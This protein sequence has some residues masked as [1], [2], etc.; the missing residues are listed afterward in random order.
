MKININN[1]KK[2]PILSSECPGWC[3]YA[4]KSIGGVIIDHMSEV[5][6]S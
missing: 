4:E 3:L 2:L 6:S 5:K 1:N